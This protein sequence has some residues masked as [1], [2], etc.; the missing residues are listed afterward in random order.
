MIFT[1]ELI[2]MGLGAGSG[3][4]FK[5][6][7][8]QEQNRTNLFNRLLENRKSG[9]DSMDRAKERDSSASG[10]WIRRFLIVSLVFGIIIAPFLLT[11]INEPTIV[12]VD[13][14][15]RSLLGLFEWGGVKHFYELHGYLITQELRCAVLAAVMYYFGN[16]SAK[17]D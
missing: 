2:S 13:S 17:S 8:V 10:Q 5:Y 11:I 1:P 4:L 15:K 14:P 7:A 9:D 3:F 6:L 16:A 12:E